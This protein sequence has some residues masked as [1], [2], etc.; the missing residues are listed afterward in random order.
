M[1]G[2]DQLQLPDYILESYLIFF[3]LRK[4]QAGKTLELRNPQRAKRDSPKPFWLGDW[5]RSPRRV[6]ERRIKADFPTACSS[7]PTPWLQI[8]AFQGVTEP[9]PD[10]SARRAKAVADALI[11]AGVPA[12]DIHTQLC[13]PMFNRPDPKSEEINRR[14]ILDLYRLSRC[15]TI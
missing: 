15:P 11:A 13:A 3:E 1:N 10:L 8:T 7:T 6:E 9:G 12:E 14:V 4:Q 5:A 2:P